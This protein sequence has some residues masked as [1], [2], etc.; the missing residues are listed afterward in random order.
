[1]PADAVLILLFPDRYGELKVVLTIRASTLRNY[2]GQ[3][4]LPG[5]MSINLFLHLRILNPSY[6]VERFSIHGDFFGKTRRRN[7]REEKS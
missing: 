7:E 2:A 5:G 4:A 6:A 3:V 1:L